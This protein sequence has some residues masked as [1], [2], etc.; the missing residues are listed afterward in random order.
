MLN[1]KDGTSN[2]SQTMSNGSVFSAAAKK[3]SFTTGNITTE[4][5]SN[6][7]YESQK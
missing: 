2:M 3:A 7:P 4:I 6:T 1:N 5:G